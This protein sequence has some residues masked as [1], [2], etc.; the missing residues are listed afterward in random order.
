MTVVCCS[1]NSA[2]MLLLSILF[3]LSVNA[4]CGKEC[5]LWF[6][7]NET[8][9]L[10]DCGDSMGGI[11]YCDSKRGEV[12][13]PVCYGMAYDE[14]MNMTLMGYSIYS[15]YVKLNS[16]CKVYQI[17]HA[18]YKDINY[19]TCS[20][21]SRTGKFCAECIKG[22]G[23][24]V[25]SYSLSCVEC[26]EKDVLRNS[27]KYLSVAFLPAT[28]FYAFIILFKISVTS[29]SMVT[30]IF[31]CQIVT[32]PA[33]LR[34][35][36]LS[37]S[38]QFVLSLFA[39]WNMDSLRLIVPPFCLHPKTTIL[40]V[41]ALDYLVGLYPL[42]L[43]FLTCTGVVLYRRCLSERVMWAP[44]DRVLTRVRRNWNCRGTMTQAFATFLTLSYVK[45]LNVSFDL[46]TAVN[47]K[48]IH[49]HNLNQSYLMLNSK[50]E[51]FGREHRN[52]GILAITMLL[53]FNITPML[54]LFL[55]SCQCFERIFIYRR[56]TLSLKPLIQSFQGCYRRDRRYF[57]G[58]FLLA[59]VIILL[60]TALVK[61]RSYYAL[62]GFYTII[63]TILL[64]LF[65]PYIEKWHNK[66][67]TLFSLLLACGLFIAG[68]YYYLGPAEPQ[69]PGRKLFIIFMT[70]LEIIFY[71]YG[72]V[73]VLQKALPTKAVALM[74]RCSQ[75]ILHY[76]GRSR[77]NDNDAF[78]D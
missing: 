8:T 49:G 35:A 44:L 13:V 51:Y 4:C 71:L 61:S 59:R 27:F 78:L 54:F 63:F 22:Y 60:T 17:L 75:C 53:V 47:L 38:N 28:A 68:F 74:L 77:D 34:M 2:K 6:R 65:E 32:M 9:N 36:L 69:I 41:I 73:M 14:E 66:V 1:L 76:R 56:I 64:I 58:I 37:N 19:V 67:A 18:T 20:N 26:S 48:D 46:L 50:I 42:L 39:A 29:G 25:Y 57:A 10:C 30:Y 3:L 55:Y 31:I 5:P 24:P 52:Y 12:A 33:L 16:V 21:L 7:L 43:I 40:Q 15:C 23:L 62:F 70:P 11:V 45:I 72:L